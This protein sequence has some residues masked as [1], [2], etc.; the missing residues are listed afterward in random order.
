MERYRFKMGQ[1]VEAPMDSGPVTDVPM[2]PDTGPVMDVVTPP[3]DVVV[4]AGTPDAGPPDSG[5]MDAA[6][7]E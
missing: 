5:D 3:M 6:D 7:G 4:D 1:C 2:S